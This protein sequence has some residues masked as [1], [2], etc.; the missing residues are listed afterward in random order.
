VSLG[1]ARFPW[2]EFL[3]SITP[4]K[5]GWTR[6]C[7][8]PQRPHADRFATRVSAPLPHVVTAGRLLDA[9]AVRSARRST[10]TWCSASSAAYGH[11]RRIARR[12]ASTAPSP[13]SIPDRTSRRAG[14]TTTARPRTWPAGGMKTVCSSATKRAPAA[15]GVRRLAVGA[16]RVA[17]D[18]L[19]VLCDSGRST[20]AADF[21]FIGLADIDLDGHLDALGGGWRARSGEASTVARG[22]RRGLAH[23]LDTS[24]PFHG[25]GC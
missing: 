4:P 11:R 21:S 5:T 16:L 25:C 10:P 17:R 22:T 14:S 9:R 2:S 13:P 1:P 20:L 19:V 24:P 12:S 7:G 18:Q 23:E 6:C 8:G 3:V 15:A